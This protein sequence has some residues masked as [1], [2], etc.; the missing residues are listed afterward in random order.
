MKNIRVGILHNGLDSSVQYAENLQQQITD[1][2][3]LVDI[4]APRYIREVL[5]IRAVPNIMVCLFCDGLEEYQEVVD[6]LKELDA[7]KQSDDLQSYYEAVNA[8]IGG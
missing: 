5:P 1:E 4:N 8:E 7:I 2:S 6:V 3:V